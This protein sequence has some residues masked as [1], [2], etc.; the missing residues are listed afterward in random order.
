MHQRFQRLFDFSSFPMDDWSEDR[1]QLDA[2]EPI[3]TTTNSSSSSTAQKTRRKKFRNT[4]AITCTKEL[5]LNDKKQFYQETNITDDRGILISRSKI[6]QTVS[7]N[8]TMPITSP[9]D[10]NVISY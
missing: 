1:K 4:Q 5:I 3:C 10:K 9:G 8:N 2:I 6:Y 7:I